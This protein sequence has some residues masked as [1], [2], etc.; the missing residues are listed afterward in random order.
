[1]GEAWSSGDSGGTHRTVEE[2]TPA[3]SDIPLYHNV[4][5]HSYELLTAL[6]AS[7]DRTELNSLVRI[8]KNCPFL[9]PRL[10]K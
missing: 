5:V 10:N 2:Q 3:T 8:E 6:T 4:V 7:L 1:M 9:P